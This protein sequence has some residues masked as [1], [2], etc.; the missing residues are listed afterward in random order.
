MSDDGNWEEIE[1][2]DE[3]E[4]DGDEE[5]RD[6]EAKEELAL[7]T[8][9]FPLICEHVDLLAVCVFLL[10]TFSLLLRSLVFAS[11]ETLHSG[12]N[13]GFFTIR[14]RRL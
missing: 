4:S 5:E 8:E 13:G 6:G 10:F 1:T 9:A 11:S 3:V 12:C 7:P 2:D 14:L